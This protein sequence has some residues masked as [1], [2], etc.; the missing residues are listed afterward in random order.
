MIKNICVFSGTRAE[1]GL[2]YWLLSDIK[3][4]K[5]LDLSLLVSGMHTSD[6]YGLTFKEIEE[7]GF[8]INE[9]IEI[10]LSSNTPSGI[11]KSMGLGLISFSDAIVKL[12]PDIF[13]V[14]GDRF[15][16]FAAAQAAMFLRVPILHIHGGEITE[17]AYDDSIR[18]SITKLSHIHCVSTEESRNRVMQ[19]GESPENVFNVGA[20]G[21]DHIHKTDLISLNELSNSINFLIDSPYFVVTFHPATL[22]NESS[23]DSFNILLK[24]LDRFEEYQLIITYP[25][26]DDGSKEITQRIEDYQKKNPKRVFSIKSLGYVRYLSAIKNSAAVIGNSS[27]GIIE[28]PSYSIPSINIGNRQKG[29]QASGSVIHCDVN[30]ESINDAIKLALSEDHLKKVNMKNNVYEKKDVSTKII[31]IIKNSNP[32]TIKKFYDIKGN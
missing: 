1:Y 17:G 4:D 25:N 21:L 7:D 22:A 29:R 32:Q 5:D 13:I 12:N 24:A 20:I 6:E 16:A 11:L 23:V 28:A 19:L 8:K 18:H 31:N 27:S 15:E 3:K 10:L 2:L 26:A 9:K 30:L 14:L